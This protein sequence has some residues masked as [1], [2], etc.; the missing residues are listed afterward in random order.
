MLYEVITAG[1]YT[2]IYSYVAV[3]CGINFELPCA[4]KPNLTS[5]APKSSGSVTSISTMRS[6]IGLRKARK[7]Q[8]NKSRP[9]VTADL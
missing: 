2:C 6:L 7:R 8:C 5:S 3:F 9:A 1:H 4:G